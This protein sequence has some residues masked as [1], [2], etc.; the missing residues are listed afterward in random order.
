MKVDPETARPADPVHRNLDFRRS[1]PEPRGGFGRPAQIEERGKRQ[2]TTPYT[3]KQESE[4]IHNSVHSFTQHLLRAYRI[5]NTSKTQTH[6]F[7]IY[8]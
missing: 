5:S 4:D 6:V 8:S 1:L 2:K 7:I 3:G